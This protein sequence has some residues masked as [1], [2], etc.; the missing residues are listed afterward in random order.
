MAMGC[1]PAHFSST[2]R[3]QSSIEQL[4]QTMYE[5]QKISHAQICLLMPDHRVAEPVY[6]LSA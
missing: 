6:T 4:W 1:Q 5:Q 2:M 3:H